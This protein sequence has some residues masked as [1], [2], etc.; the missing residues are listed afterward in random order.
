MSLPI[1]IY[2]LEAI[3]KRNNNIMYNSDFNL[4]KKHGKINSIYFNLKLYTNFLV[5]IAESPS[6]Y[7]VS[8]C[9]PTK[10]FANYHVTVTHNHHLINLRKIKLFNIIHPYLLIWFAYKF[11]VLQVSDVDQNHEKRYP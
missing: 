4:N 6:Q 5:N 9:F 11:N 8:T 7:S 1:I 2:I 3:H 10:W